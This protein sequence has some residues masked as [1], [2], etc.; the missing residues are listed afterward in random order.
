MTG[1]ADNK[2]VS[3]E[4]DGTSSHNKRSNCQVRLL[5]RRILAK[6]NLP[7]IML[8]MLHHV[9]TA[10][11]HDCVK[12]PACMDVASNHVLIVP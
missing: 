3:D 2:M 10:T 6:R 8:V 4:S 12:T 7:Y 11:P 9:L 1:Q 5:K